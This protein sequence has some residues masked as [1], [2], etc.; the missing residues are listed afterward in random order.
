MDDLGNYDAGRLYLITYTRMIS[1]GDEKG[2]FYTMKSGSNIFK[3]S[4]LD[5]LFFWNVAL[6]TR[7]MFHSSIEARISFAY[8][9]KMTST[10]ANVIIS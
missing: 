5:L 8:L 3:I 4:L 9:L 10:M 7:E 6:L 1:S 2:I